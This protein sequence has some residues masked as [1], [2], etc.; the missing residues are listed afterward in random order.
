[1]KKYI[2]GLTVVSS[3]FALNIDEAVEAGKKFSYD[4]KSKDEVIKSKK[5]LERDADS[6]FKPKVDLAFSYGAKNENYSNGDKEQ[7]LFNFKV[8]Y[9]LFSGFRD[10]YTKLLREADTISSEYDRDILLS[11]RVYEIKV[12]YIDILKKQEILKTQKEALELLKSQLKDTESFYKAGVRLKND[13]LEVKV[14]VANQKQ[15]LLRAKLDVDIAKADLRRLTGLDIDTLESISFESSSFDEASLEKQMYANRA[16]LKYL[17]QLKKMNG[18]ER[19]VIKSENYP[20]VDLEANYNRFGGDKFLEDDEVEALLSVKYNLYNG[21]ST[22]AR[23]GAN[24]ANFR[25]LDFDILEL[26]NSLSFDLKT[27]IFDILNSKEV[28][29]VAFDSIEQAKENYKL[30]ENRYKN[31][32]S[33]STNLLDARLYLTEAKENYIKAKYDLYSL[34][35]KLDRVVGR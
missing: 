30:S 35:A 3:L 29:D 16:E 1:L 21:G 7:S 33:T 19:E 4:I 6:S 27:T 5:E 28:V 11:N 13:F 25:K 24:L 22:E 31:G 9:N 26:K 12:A 20:S 17:E 14:Q 15:K 32:I 34:N 8:S 23:V 2:L 10:K 18:F